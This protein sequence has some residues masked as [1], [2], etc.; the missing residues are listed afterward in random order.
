MVSYS[1]L[2][3]LGCVRMLPDSAQQ[4]ERSGRHAL[5]TNSAPQGA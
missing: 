3:R 2:A 1:A 4:V 5:G